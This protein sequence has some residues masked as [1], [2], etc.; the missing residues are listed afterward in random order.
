MST[1]LWCKNC[2]ND[3]GSKWE[4]WCELR[5]Q[6]DHKEKNN[7]GRTSAEVLAALGIHHKCCRVVMLTT[8]DLLS[9]LNGFERTKTHGRD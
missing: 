4:A 3:L 9:L 5:P 7:D 6:D 1:P 2:G 8:N